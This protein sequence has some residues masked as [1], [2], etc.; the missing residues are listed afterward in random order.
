MAFKLVKRFRWVV[1][2]LNDGGQVH[3]VDVPDA[4][5]T[6]AGSFIVPHL[7][8]RLGRWLHPLA[9]NAPH[10]LKRRRAVL[11]RHNHAERNV[12][13]R[14]RHCHPRV[15]L[16]LA[17]GLAPDLLEER[18]LWQHF[19]Y[20]AFDD[21]RV[22]SARH[23][24]VRDLEDHPLMLFVLFRGV[25]AFVVVVAQADPHLVLLRNGPERPARRHVRRPDGCLVSD[26]AATAVPDFGKALLGLQLHLK[27]VERSLVQG[28]VGLFLRAASSLQVEFSQ[29]CNL[30]RVHA[31]H[32]CAVVDA[33]DA[34]EIVCADVKRGNKV[35]LRDQSILVSVKQVD[36]V[37][38][39]VRVQLAPEPLQP[40]VQ[41][42]GCQRSVPG[43]VKH[44][45]RVGSHHAPNLQ[46]GLHPGDHGAKLE[47]VVLVWRRE[48]PGDSCLLPR[49]LL[50][51]PHFA[52]VGEKVL[53]GFR[54]VVL[55]RTE[56]QVELPLLVLHL[57]V[58][59]PVITL[60]HRNVRTSA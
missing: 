35:V 54:P 56:Q 19:V 29:L 6:A 26:A 49:G 28:K 15:A 8:C 17:P 46:R 51:P 22:A 31:A 52:D 42:G 3:V 21:V 13:V 4:A 12:P 57:A 60:S 40:R 18:W 2:P 20:H 36:Q 41:L 9:W 47:Q 30:V 25:K 37:A 59:V 24:H 39:L 50:P 43:A 32:V 7:F 53:P 34:F 5:W 23:V 16:L 14:R 44:P 10:G 33:T 58:Q 11:G 1:V 38:H 45:E 48:E 55:Q 27:V